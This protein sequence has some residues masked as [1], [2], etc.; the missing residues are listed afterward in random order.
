M[1][2]VGYCRVSSQDQIDGTSLT[3]QENQIKAYAALKGFDLDGLFI[4]PGVS[5]SRPLA[6]RPEGGKMRGPEQG[7]SSGHQIGRAHV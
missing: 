2:A 4:D 6:T 7:R 3:A 5:G 1:K